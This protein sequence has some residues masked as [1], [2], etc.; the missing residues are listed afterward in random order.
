MINRCRRTKGQNVLERAVVPQ[1]CLQE[2]F[3]LGDEEGSEATTKRTQWQ[4]G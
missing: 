3:P 1:A 2:P 4:R